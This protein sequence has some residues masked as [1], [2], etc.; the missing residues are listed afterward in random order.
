ML[1]MVSFASS[2][3][4][5]KIS[6]QSHQ[7]FVFSLETAITRKGTY[8]VVQF[9]L[10][11]TGLGCGPHPIQPFIITMVSVNK[12]QEGDEAVFVLVKSDWKSRSPVWKAVDVRL[13]FC[14]KGAGVCNVEVKAVILSAGLGSQVSLR[15]CPGDLCVGLCLLL[16]LWLGFG[17]RS[18]LLFDCLLLK[19]EVSKSAIQRYEHLNIAVYESLVFPDHPAK[20]GEVLFNGTM[21]YPFAWIAF[22]YY[23]E[24]PPIQGLVSAN[25]DVGVLPNWLGIAPFAIAS[26]ISD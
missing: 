6:E 19:V 16:G 24:E 14:K 8:D 26:A 18:S 20:K 10:I 17:L 25:A 22:A 7:V 12:L 9:L 11:H 2:E 15:Q 13:R 1:N 23:P 4:V 3:S 5:N 21:R